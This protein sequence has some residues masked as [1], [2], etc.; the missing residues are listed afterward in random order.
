MIVGKSAAAGV[1]AKAQRA[2]AQRA[3]AQRTKA[4]RQPSERCVRN[5]RGKY[6]ITRRETAAADYLFPKKQAGLEPAI[7]Q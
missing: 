3:K 7:N 5:T 2:K 1:C 6:I 4:Q